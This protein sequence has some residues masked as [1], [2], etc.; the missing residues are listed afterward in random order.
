MEIFLIRL[1]Q[2]MLAISILVLFHEGGHFFFSKLFGVRVEKFYLFF[3][4]W[5][6]LFEFKPKKSDTTYGI[7]WLPL[8]GYCKISGMIDESFDTKQ[9]A[10]PA[11]PWEFRTKPAWQR[12]LI[13]LGGVIVNFFLAL[14]IY[15]MVLFHWGDNYIKVK[16]MTAGMKFNTEAKALGFKDGDILVGTEKG[17][18]KTFDVDM[19]R[20]LSVARKVNIIRNGKPMSISMPGNLDLLNMIKS[21]PRFAMYLSPNTID[22]VIPHSPAMKVGLRKG[23]KIVAFNGKTVDSY[24][25][26]TNEI[27]RINDVLASANTHTDSLKALTT[28]IAFVHQGDSVPVKTAITLASDVRI[29]AVFSNI[30]ATYRQTHVEYSFFESLPAGAAYGWNMLKGYVGDMKYIFSADGAKSLGGFGTI[31]SLFPPVWDW[32]MFWMMT[33]FLSII[34]AFM[35][36]L[37][38]PALDG[39]HVLFL[40]YEIITRRKPG[41]KF[42]IRAEYIG[43][44]ILI[45]LMVVANLNDI[46][47]ALGYM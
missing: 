23:D 7:G 8:G 28:T 20:D 6:H 43:I 34:L 9:M 21:T 3:D 13:M 16:D 41:E 35:N 17:E 37:P 12:L 22:S 14:F 33:A 47:R 24:N 44:S 40:M 5:F 27:D 4:P 19:Y 10:Q 32:Q 1:L 18:F 38:I 30:L 26:F 2:F 31:G 42:M 29:G 46:L 15:S 39:G 36:I 45:L 11:Q 25:D